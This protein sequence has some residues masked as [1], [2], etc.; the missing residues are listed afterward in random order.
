M[1]AGLR[2]GQLRRPSA[3]CER[4]GMAGRVRG[5][6]AARRQLA[7]ARGRQPQRRARRRRGR[8]AC[9]RRGISRRAG[10][11]DEGEGRAMRHAWLAAVLLLPAP[12]AW[13]QTAPAAAPRDCAVC[14]ELALVPPGQFQMGS[15]PDAVELD[16]DERRVAAGRLVILAP[17]PGLEPRDHR[18]RVP[19][20]RRGDRCEGGAWLPG[21]GRQAMDPGPGSQL[22]RS[23]DSRRRRAMTTRWSA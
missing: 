4:L 8:R 9:R 11:R 21:V 16:P 12:A 23:R 20:F 18:R 14:P 3:R 1:G 15:A 19:P 6:R 10:P 22:A 5:T 2:D 13:P 17:V 7:H